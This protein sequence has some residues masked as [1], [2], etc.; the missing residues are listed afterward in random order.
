MGGD[1]SFPPC[2]AFCG[3]AVLL[4]RP[5][6]ALP[7]CVSLPR[8]W[9][10]QVL[11]GARMPTDGV[12]VEGQSHAD[13]SMLTG[14]SGG[15]PCLVPAGACPP[16]GVRCVPALGPQLLGPAPLPVSGVRLLWGHSCWGLPSAPSASLA[17]LPA[18]TPRPR[19]HSPSTP[20][21]VLPGCSTRQERAWGCCDRGNGGGGRATTDQGD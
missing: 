18:P 3:V 14:E 8:L 16:S 4:A 10:P 20:P 9:L 1:C 11:P 19:P 7:S 13:E 17:S 12:V 15:F 5:T 2:R 6:P 21:T